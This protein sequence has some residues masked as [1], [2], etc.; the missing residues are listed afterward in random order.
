MIQSYTASQSREWK[1][2]RQ[3]AFVQDVLA[4]G[5]RRPAHLISFQQVSRKLQLGNVR[6]LDLQVV[7]LNQIVGSV[8]RYHDFNRAFLP[9]LDNLQERWQRIEQLMTTG[10]E[11]PPIE[12]YKVGRAYFVRDGNHRVSVAQHHQA[13]SIKAYVWEYETDLPLEPGCDVDEL[14]CRYAHEAFLKQTNVD[15]LC[16][17]FNIRLTQP[18]GYEVLLTEIEAFQQ[19]IARIDEREVPFDEAV[20]LWCEMC[21]APIVDIISRRHVLQE[22]PG[23]TET[24]LY[25]W[26]SRNYEELGGRYGSGVLMEEAADDLAKQY[27][28]KILPT[29]QVRQVGGSVAGFVASSLT[30]WWRFALQALRNVRTVQRP[31]SGDH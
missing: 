7:A 12:L 26:L 5:M 17:D 22:F 15:R 3:A 6:Y 18:D 30:A 29:R 13:R 8:D 1:R 10:R 2:A 23:R 16:P 4:A 9:R 21:Y 25:L 28:E 14:L 11:L 24:D 31:P 19:I 27:G 20:T